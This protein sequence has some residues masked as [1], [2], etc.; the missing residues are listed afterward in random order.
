MQ[1]ETSFPLERL[2]KTAKSKR[3]LNIIKEA[4]KGGGGGREQVHAAFWKPR[5]LYV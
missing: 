3:V 5:G 4:K 2:T 1:S